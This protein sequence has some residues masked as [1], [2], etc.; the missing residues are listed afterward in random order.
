DAMAELGRERPG[1]LA[2]VALNW[3]RAHGAM[4]IPGLRHPDQV[5]RAAEALS[6]S[7]TEDE[8]RHLDALVLAPGAARMPANPFE[9]A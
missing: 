2:A 9:S 4:P 7:L 1:G 6:W 3:C 8:R 5:E